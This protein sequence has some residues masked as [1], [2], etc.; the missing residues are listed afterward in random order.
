MY[1]YSKLSFYSI[2]LQTAL[3]LFN[4]SVKNDVSGC[5]TNLFVEFLL[6]TLINLLTGF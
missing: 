5:K 6:T 3:F 4:R 2:E 1:D